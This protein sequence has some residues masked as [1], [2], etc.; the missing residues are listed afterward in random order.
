MVYGGAPRPAGFE[1]AEEEIEKMN[2][3][4]EMMIEE[5]ENNG[6]IYAVKVNN[7]T[8]E[9]KRPQVILS[10]I[11]IVGD[12]IIGHF[13]TL[14]DDLF[15]IGKSKI[16]G[17]GGE[18][19]THRYMDKDVISWLHKE[20]YMLINKDKCCDYYR[21]LRGF[22]EFNN[23]VNEINLMAKTY[24]AP[25]NVP[26]AAVVSKSDF[27]SKSGTITSTDSN[28]NHIKRIAKTS[29]DYRYFMELYN[30]FED[31]GFTN[32][33]HAVTGSGSI[34]AADAEIIRSGKLKCSAKDAKKAYAILEYEAKFKDIVDA[35]GGRGDYFK[36]AI[37]FCFNHPDVDN[38]VLLKRL[39]KN[40]DKMTRI[41]SIRDA[42]HQIERVYNYRRNPKVSIE[43]DYLRSRNI[44]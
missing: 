34:T 24:K 13:F 25:K 21:K 12:K 19:F 15:G 16:F 20:G 5:M 38:N 27:I 14:T 18:H 4:E 33:Y 43:H 22:G 41:Q 8:E 23:I 30:I 35:V 3:L 29:K 32:V 28:M 42:L 40:Y 1:F 36:I 17:K 10:Y 31:L 39:R 6:T 37:A 9:H 7:R 11:E 2:Y 26:G 44:R